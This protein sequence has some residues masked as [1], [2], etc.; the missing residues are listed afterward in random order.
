[1]RCVVGLPHRQLRINAGGQVGAGLGAGP[2]ASHGGHAQWLCSV[3]PPRAAA[4]AEWS[5]PLLSK[6]RPARCSST[7]EA[8]AS[9]ASP[10]AASPSGQCRELPLEQALA[11][12][13]VLGGTTG[14]EAGTPARA[15]P[16]ALAPLTA[17]AA[18][19]S[20]STPADARST[21][22]GGGGS[23][24]SPALPS[25]SFRQQLQ[26]RGRQ[27]SVPA[28]TAR[29]SPSPLGHA[30]L[31]QAAAPQ[32]QTPAD[33]PPPAASLV[34]ELGRLRLHRH[35]G[36]ATPRSPRRT[37]R[38]VGRAPS[39]AA[40]LPSA[41]LAAPT[42]RMEAPSTAAELVATAPPPPWQ[43]M[44]PSSAV[45]GKARGAGMLAVQR[46]ERQQLPAAAAVAPCALAAGKA[47]D[48]TTVA[49][50]VEDHDET[51][52]Q[53]A[54]LSVLRRRLLGMAPEL[55]LA[56]LVTAH[57]AAAAA[58]PSAAEAWRTSVSTWEEV[59]VVLARMA[60]LRKAAEQ[61]LQRAGGAGGSGDPSG[62]D[63]AAL[64]ISAAP[65]RAGRPVF[66]RQK[67]RAATEQQRQ[68]QGQRQGPS[69][70]TLARL[71]RL[72]ALSAKGGQLVQR[73]GQQVA[74]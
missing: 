70:A 27:A 44:L 21:H 37:P 6:L 36:A 39:L 54:A 73:L 58:K 48:S 59:Q 1:M 28:S 24:A 19:A 61:L 17:T 14:F 46:G 16:P 9:T 51:E 11:Q 63:F 33:A 23:P 41:R 34:E 62:V 35:H 2:G 49:P 22:S 15:R 8:I 53:E 56:Q 60:E 5:S 52:Q 43:P 47:S 66:A 12:R 40:S 32:L 25:T 74:A 55:A 29:T 13:L 10:A 68:G 69:E 50:T 4:M 64:S 57:P 38:A 20:H 72:K 45:V 65:C 67:G 3:A 26:Q 31:H 7:Q 30:L 42:P 18:R 71:A